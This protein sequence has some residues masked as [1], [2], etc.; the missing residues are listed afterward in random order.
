MRTNHTAVLRGSEPRP[1]FPA[2]P[3]FRRV[4]KLTPAVHTV[5]IG[6]RDL[7]GGVM[8]SAAHIQIVSALHRRVLGHKEFIVVPGQML[9][10]PRVRGFWDFPTR[11]RGEPGVT[12]QLRG[13]TA[14]SG[15]DLH[16]VLGAEV[17]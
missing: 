13:E 10:R 16:A 4:T 15:T 17:T 9:T 3:I 14:R 11:V 1:H 12:Q 5:G 8:V 2:A 7:F 6:E